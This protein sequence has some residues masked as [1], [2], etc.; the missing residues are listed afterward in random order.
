MEYE[1]D[2]KGYYEVLG[3]AFDIDAKGLKLAYREVV[4]K[5]HP[6]VNKGEAAHEHFVKIRNAYDILGDERARADYDKSH[7]PPP[8]PPPPRA[9]SEQK[10]Y[11][12]KEN[13]D[14]NYDYG[15]DSGDTQDDFVNHQ[16]AAYYQADEPAMQFGFDAE[17]AESRQRGG[18][19]Q[20][21]VCAETGEVTAQPRAVRY[22]VI[23]SFLLMTWK[24]PIYGVYSRR[25]ADKVALRASLYTWL[26]GWWGIL[27]PFHTIKALVINLMGGEMPR[28]EN[29]ILLGEQGVAFKMLGKLDLARSTIDMAIRFAIDRTIK[30]E[31]IRYRQKLG[32]MRKKLALKKSWA[33]TESKAFWIQLFPLL[34]VL[35][36]IFYVAMV[37]FFPQKM[38]A[39][40][41]RIN[42]SSIV[43][44]VQEIENS[45]IV[46]V[47]EP[48]IETPTPIKE[49]IYAPAP[50][51]DE[52]VSIY[53]RGD[54]FYV[55]MQN[56]M[57]NILPL[58]SGADEESPV[59]REL[60]PFTGVILDA[61]PS[62]N[63]WVRVSSLSGDVSGYVRFDNIN[64]GSGIEAYAAF[65]SRSAGNPLGNGETLQRLSGIY[66]VNRLTI[67][68]D[69]DMDMVVV[70]RNRIGQAIYHFVV[71][72]GSQAS[73][74]DIPN[75][76]YNISYAI[77]RDYSRECGH[78]IYQM[79][80]F[81]IHESVNFG[82]VAIGGGVVPVAR[83][84]YNFALGVGSLPNMENDGNLGEEEI[85]VIRVGQEEFT[86]PDISSVVLGDFL[87]E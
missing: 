61:P 41:D 45:S 35:A 2:S 24:K 50:M 84:S 75:G 15:A 64:Y 10:S 62:S 38:V 66:G 53:G 3:V 18:E 86:E 54:V 32:P 40:K 21:V 13:N 1:R 56:S 81:Q 27:G 70:L 73:K 28:D 5:Y 8:K 12:K 9:K 36:L 19:V 60:S 59:I 14:R 46:N 23:I 82:S 26:F 30:K 17:A 39:F 6:D 49:P 48:I 83:N 78:F 71:L 69:Y 7:K 77:G 68:N 47:T 80:A 44:R 31:L 72:A 79:Q 51:I 57:E 11:R 76:R 37:I 16:E 55:S 65:C 33:L 85:D 67:R 42:E 20:L 74:R 63:G 29:A 43:Q 22:W 87:R 52:P 4:K 58:F 34:T 25:G